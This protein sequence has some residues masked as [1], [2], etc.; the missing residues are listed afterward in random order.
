MRTWLRPALDTVTHLY[1]MLLKVVSHILYYARNIK[2]NKHCMGNSF[3][4]DLYSDVSVKLV[5]CF[6]FT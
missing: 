5:V 4:F 3:D 6:Q 2:N 1:V